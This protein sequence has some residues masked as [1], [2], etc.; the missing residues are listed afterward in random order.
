MCLQYK[1]FENTVGKVEIAHYELFLLFPQYFRK[2]SI[3]HLQTF[4]IWK[5]LKLLFRE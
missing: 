4:Y 2:I 5:S 1:P 3:Y